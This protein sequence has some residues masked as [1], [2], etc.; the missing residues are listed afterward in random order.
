MD[1][2]RLLTCHLLERVQNNVAVFFAGLAHQTAKL[3]EKQGGRN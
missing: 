3:V 2:A 1:D